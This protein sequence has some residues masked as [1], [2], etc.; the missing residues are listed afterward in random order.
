MQYTITS[1]IARKLAAKVSLSARI[2]ALCEESLGTEKGIESRAALER[3]LKEEQ[4]RG[5]KVRGRPLLQK[6]P[7]QAYVYKKFV[8]L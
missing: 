7:E 2:D 6:P 3:V 1:Q 5:P 4:E 8:F